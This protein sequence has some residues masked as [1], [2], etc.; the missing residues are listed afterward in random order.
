MAVRNANIIGDLWPLCNRCRHI[1]QSHD[2][3]GCAERVPGKCPTC[4]FYANRIPCQCKKYEGPTLGEFMRDNLTMEEIV[5]Y[6]KEWRVRLE[7]LLM[8]GK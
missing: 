8:E 3:S 5:F 7:V 1:A 4:G 2:T 6:E